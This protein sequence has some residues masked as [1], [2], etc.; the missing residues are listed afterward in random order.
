MSGRMERLGAAVRRLGDRHAVSDTHLGCFRI[1]FCLYYLL[2]L[3]VPNYVWITRASPSFFYPPIGIPWFFPGFPPSLVFYA[4]SALVLA[5][6]I[7]LLLGWRTRQVG[8]ALTALLLFGHGFKY[9]FAKIDHDIV[10]V[11]VP[12][13]MSWSGWGRRFSIDA[14]RGSAREASRWGGLIMAGLLAF[15]FFTAGWPKLR[16]WVD[17]DLSTQGARSWVLR[18]YYLNGRQD[19]LSPTFARMENPWIW[20]MMDLGAVVF[21]LGF[22]IAILAPR[23]F[24]FWVAIAVGFHFWN[25]LMLNIPFTGMMS[26]YLF[27]VSW[28]RVAA[29]PAFGRASAWVSQRRRWGVG[30]LALYLVGFVAAQQLGSMPAAILVTPLNLLEV[31][32]PEYYKGRAICIL[33]IALLVAVAHVLAS[34]RGRADDPA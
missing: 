26:V 2:V 15:G 7:A 28:D 12:L 14:L 34:L 27:F 19:W 1:A 9:S 33:T 20:E 29:T 25:N 8:I 30:L 31:F 11:M 13:A 17:F 24:R 21:E 3:G 23:A 18:G 32:A 5:G 22:M 4:V 10:H 16:G 6:Y